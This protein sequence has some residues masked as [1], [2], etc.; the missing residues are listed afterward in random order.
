[1]RHVRT[2][3]ATAVL[4]GMVSTSPAGPVCPIEDQAHCQSAATGQFL[5]PSDRLL[6]IRRADDFRPTGSTISQVCFFPCFVGNGFGFECSAEG[7][8]PPDDYILK[9]YEDDFGIPGPLAAGIPVDGLSLTIDAKANSDPGGGSRCW[10]YSAPVAP[11]LGITVT[12]NDCYWLE[13]TGLGDVRAEGTCTVYWLS[14]RDGNDYAVSDDNG[15]YEV[16]DIPHWFGRGDQA[17]CLDAGLFGATNPPTSLDGGCGDVPVA[18]CHPG[19]TGAIC[20]DGQTFLECVG[21]PN[22]PNVDVVVLPY[23]SCADVAAM[24]GC[25]Q[26]PNDLCENAIFPIECQNLAPIATPGYCTSDCYGWF[27]A[28]CDR[29]QGTAPSHTCPLCGDCVAL[30]PNQSA[31][32][33]KFDTDNRLAGTDG[34]LGTSCA[35]FNR[36]QADVWY[37]Y[38]APCTGYM[39][40]SMCKWNYY[41]SVLQIFGDHTPTCLTCPITNNLNSLGCN[42]DACETPSKVKVDVVKDGCYTIRLGGYSHTGSLN[43]TEEAES[44]LDLTVVCNALYSADP[45]MAA[46][47][48]HD[49]RKNRY[50][51]FVP[52]NGTKPIAFRVDK[53]TAPVGTCWVGPPDA[54]GNSRCLPVPTFRAWTEPVIHVGDCFVAPV[55][56]Y[57]IVGVGSDGTPN[58][59]VLPVETIRLPTLNNKLWGDVAGSNNGSEWT[60]PNLFTNVNDILAVVAYISN[61]AIKPTFQMVNV[62]AVSSADPCLNA[63]VN[64][65]DVFIVVKAAAGDAYPFATNP[66]NCPVC[67]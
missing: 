30:F 8:T 31:Y 4:T 56:D 60:P 7:E 46:P 26:P 45:P 38:V 39:T 50:L 35:G 22:A 47:S 21:P 27:P 28:A 53:L 48:P 61:A 10:R 15:I 63:F 17:F 36:F 52:N 16:N 43:G 19:G 40:V 41:D 49:R 2:I 24:G 55:N 32:A 29:S 12:P 13:I 11:P 65:A 9:I 5:F 20:V 23:L 57:Q 67:P 59:N 64:T 44:V 14:S 66:A 3:L 6:G 33:C 18:C 34:P 62:Q 42:D 37:Q 25:P 58:P 51:S 1:M 54:S